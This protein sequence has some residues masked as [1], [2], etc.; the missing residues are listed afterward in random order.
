MVLDDDTCLEQ[1]LRQTEQGRQE[2]TPDDREASDGDH[3]S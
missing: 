3:G 1:Q 2:D